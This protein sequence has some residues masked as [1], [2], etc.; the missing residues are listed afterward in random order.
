MFD[1]D[2]FIDNMARYLAYLHRTAD[3]YY[4]STLRDRDM[5]DFFVNKI[6]AVRDI[7]IIFKCTPEVWAK[8]KTI[9]D[10]TNSGRFGYT[11]KDGKIVK[12]EE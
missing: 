7:C 12:E 2:T 9:Y 10:F 6:E 5:I 11:L 4:Y 1:K 3:S 8:A